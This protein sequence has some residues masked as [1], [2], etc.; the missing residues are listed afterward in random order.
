[1]KYFFS[2]FMF[3]FLAC[4]EETA[5]NTDKVKP[6]SEFN[7][8][9]DGEFPKLSW[10]GNANYTSLILERKLA[11]DF[12]ELAKL[13][14]NALSYTDT[15]AMTDSLYTYRVQTVLENDSSEYILKEFKTSFPA[16]ENIVVTAVDGKIVVAWEDKSDFETG[17]IVERKEADGDFIKIADLPENTVS[18]TDSTASFGTELFYRVRA[19]TQK[20]HSEYLTSTTVTTDFPAPSELTVEITSD[21]AL[22][23]EWKD[24]ATFE[25]GYKIERAENIGGFVEIATLS[26]NETSFTDKGLIWTNSYRYKVRAFTENNFSEYSE[27]T[28][29]LSIIQ[30][31]KPTNV[32]AV[33]EN[34]KVTITWKDNCTF[35]QKY[36]VQRKDPE[37]S[38]WTGPFLDPNAES[39]VDSTITRPGELSYR[40]RVFANGKFGAKSDVVKVNIDVL[41]T[42]VTVNGGGFDMGTNDTNYPNANPAHS[43]VLNTFYMSK[44]EVTNKQMAEVMNWAYEK[45]D[46][47]KE[48]SGQSIRTTQ[49][50][51]QYLLKTASRIYWGSGNDRLFYREEHKNHPVIDMTWYGAVAYANFLSEMQGLEPVYSFDDWSADHTKNG[52]RLPTEA[53]WEFAARGGLNSQNYVYS[54]SNNLNEVAWNANNSGNDTHPVGEKKAN[55][56]GLYDMLGNVSEFCYDWYDQNYYATSPSHNPMG[57]ETPTDDRVV[58][59]ASYNFSL[60]KAFRPFYRS[61]V[62]PAHF[63]TFGKIGFR[64]V[65]SFQ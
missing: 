24:N 35:E 9:Q 54:G 38:G 13:D 25:K 44:Y 62:A 6:V 8:T 10:K 32:Q 65:R 51:K 49:G 4:E 20:N 63:E 43:V 34:G 59:G 37:R 45:G 18:Y 15:T 58:R 23:I 3:L 48:Y 53:E 33:Y 21:S 57:P 36:I 60:E 27:E 5:G 41:P 64:L 2:A 47:S 52:Y 28:T 46:I 22:T 50:D 12:V 29:P 55:E 61:L 31:T 26:A 19:F 17:F 7:I 40:V 14:E 30:A 56:L 16:P 1:M 39:H 42:E 11:N